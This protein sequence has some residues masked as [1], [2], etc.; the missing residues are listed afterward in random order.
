[1][2]SDD[3]IT[4]NEHINTSVDDQFEL[5]TDE[6]LNENGAITHHF[7]CLDRTVQSYTEPRCS[8]EILSQFR[9]AGANDSNEQEDQKEKKQS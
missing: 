5:I 8:D 7:H 9:L 2:N 1:M 6:W 3:P 4:A